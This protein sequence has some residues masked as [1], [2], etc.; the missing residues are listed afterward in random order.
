M[1]SFL[2]NIFIGLLRIHSSFFTYFFKYFESVK[3]KLLILK[4]GGDWICRISVKF[5]EFVNPASGDEVQAHVVR[6]LAAWLT[7]GALEWLPGG[8][9]TRAILDWWPGTVA[10]GRA[11]YTFEISFAMFSI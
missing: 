5:T 1:M 8:G 3:V 2:K 10:L 11:H 7:L 6:A 9:G 4:F